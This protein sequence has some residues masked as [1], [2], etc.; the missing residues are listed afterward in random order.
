[1]SD[2]T[3][4]YIPFAK[5]EESDDGTITIEGIASSE[6]VD[7]HGE[8]ITADAMKNAL[9]DF[10]KY[11]TGNLREMHQ[12][13]AAGTIEKAEIGEDGRTYITAKVV[14][15]VAVK[16]VQM[17]VYKAFSIGG[18]K[19][20]DGYDKLTK[21]ITAL[22]LTEIS[23]V[24]RPANPEAVI[25]MWKAEDMN[26]N[27]TE[28]EPILNA[29][30][31]E[32]VRGQS[33]IAKAL[34]SPELQSMIAQAIA[35]GIAKGL[36]TAQTTQEI[37]PVQIVVAEEKQVSELKKAFGALKVNADDVTKSADV[38]E[39]GMTSVADFAYVINSLTWLQ[40]CA[41]EE[42][43]YE[44]DNSPLPAKLADLIGQAGQIL[45]EMAQEELG[46]LM[47]EMKG[48]EAENAITVLNNVVANSVYA[49]DLKKS[50]DLIDIIKA[51]ARNSAKDK[52]DIQK[53]HD[54][55]MGLGAA[56]AEPEV[57]T[58][59]HDHSHDISKAD[60]EKVAGELGVLRK[61]LET[62]TEENSIL[63]S[64]YDELKKSYD[65][66]P[67]M[68]KAILKV[69]G[70]GDELSDLAGDEPK[71]EPVLKQDG[72][73]DEAATAIK[74]IHSGGGRSLYQR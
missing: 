33:D 16:K 17:G 40:R 5:I 29:D 45:V 68:P 35:D 62:I 74:A 25:T 38:I 32:M 11:G 47:A 26:G 37:N 71:V 9:P 64:N 56:C 53:A 3:G 7:A 55:L 21:T 67:Q 22:K 63:K 70:K 60:F 51:G 30:E 58:E 4:L 15:P 46:E 69:V 6:C 73:I 14:D 48:E 52:A 24:D 13:L 42:A 19:L 59:K 72:T 39:K 1:M 31:A 66:L 41:N 2:K 18:S 27:Q 34:A 65:A 43:E 49:E 36:Q 57:I 12:P 10:F 50:N 61:S 23:L 54:L 44:G 28:N 8:T 20:K